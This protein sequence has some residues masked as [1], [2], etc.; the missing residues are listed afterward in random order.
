MTS[1]SGA[2]LAALGLGALPNAALQTDVQEITDGAPVALLFDMTSGQ[3]LYSRNADRRFIPASITKVMSAFVAFELIDDGQ[4]SLD[5]SMTMSAAAGEEWHR[6]GSTMFLDT[7]DEVSV[8]TLLQGITSVS[9]NDASIVLAE[10]ALGS[11]DKWTKRMNQTALELKMYDSHFGTPNGWPDDGKTFTTAHDLQLLALALIKKHPDK[12]ARYF[13]KEGLRYNGY[14]QANHDPIS[15]VVEGAD[16]IKTGYTNQAGHGFLGSAQRGG[17]RLIM[18][19]AA[20]DNE[21]LRAEIARD[22]INWGFDNFERKTWFS[23]SKRIGNARVQNGMEK[24]V[25][26]ETGD[27]VLIA[28]PLSAKVAPTFKIVYDGPLEAPIS[29]GEM[30]AELE[31]SV[32]GLPASRIPLLAA[33]SVNEA[34]ALQR[35][36]NA[37]DRWFG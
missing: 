10:G 7:G 1:I 29:K 23:G 27:S 30:V 13:G 2:I 21:P 18:V 4:L 33:K 9:A 6:K 11:V 12:Y 35:I 24:V 25:A 34:N 32:P 3:T 28:L 5:Q 26:L 16:G 20:I 17:A 19:T 14:A 22:L 15:G 36:A 37:F 8:H 31:V